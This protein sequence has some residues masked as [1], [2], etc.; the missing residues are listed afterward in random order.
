MKKQVIA[1]D[2][3]DVL[4]TH[5]NDFIKFSNERWGTNLSVDDY[6]ENWEM[7][8]GVTHAELIERSDVFHASGLVGAYGHRAEAI[9]TLRKLKRTYKLVVVTS[10][11]RVIMEETARWVNSYFKN[12]FDEIHYAGMWDDHAVDAHKLTK[13]EICQQIGADYLIDDQLKHCIAAAGAGIKALLF[14][15][16]SWNK[17]NN[18]PDGVVRVQ[19]WQEVE[20]YFYVR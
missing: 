12:I 1:V 19:T 10:R 17:N 2:I 11:R 6:D 3:D 8:W 20:D 4:S 18:L 5:A 14:G 16:Y 7:M 15:E 9:E 13:A